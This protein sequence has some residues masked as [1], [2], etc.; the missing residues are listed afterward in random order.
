MR[1]LLAWQHI[2][3]NERVLMIFPGQGLTVKLKRTRT[4]QLRTK[5][6]GFMVRYITPST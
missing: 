5:R 2:F 1:L 3:G 4:T 6:G